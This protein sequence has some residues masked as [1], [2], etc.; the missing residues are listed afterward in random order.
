MTSPGTDPMPE[1]PE[2]PE[3]DVARVENGLKVTH[4]DSGTSAL[5][6][7]NERAARLAG[8]RLRIVADLVREIPF[9]TGDPT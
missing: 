4:R 1:L 8:L 5:V 7:D 2:I 3:C 6:P 9:T